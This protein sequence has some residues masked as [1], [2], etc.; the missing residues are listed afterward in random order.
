MAFLLVFIFLFLWVAYRRFNLTSQNYTGGER[1]GMTGVREGMIL[2]RGRDF[3]S[4]YRII[5]I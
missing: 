2:V 3:L 5:L 4:L 1:C